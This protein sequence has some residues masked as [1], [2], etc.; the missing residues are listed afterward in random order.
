LLARLFLL[1]LLTVGSAQVAA[2]Q[3][4]FI[5]QPLKCET[6]PIHRTF[7]G[8]EWM[9]Y[10]CNDQ[11]SMVVASAPGNPALPFYFFL[12]P[13]AGTYQI[14]GEGAGDQRASRAAGDN[15]STLTP[16]DFASLLAATKAV[17]GRQ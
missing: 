5:S 2:Q 1:C 12:K 14:S 16:A 10:S 9:V 11:A 7:G 15:L 6:G 17:S 4:P 13:E 8:T 3:T